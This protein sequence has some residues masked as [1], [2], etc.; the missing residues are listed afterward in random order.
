MCLR[1][2]IEVGVD[3]SYVFI[4]FVTVANVAHNIKILYGYI[5]HRTF[6]KSSVRKALLLLPKFSLI[7]SLYNIF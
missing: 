6:E 1:F 3:P 4:I 5:F 7:V 2:A